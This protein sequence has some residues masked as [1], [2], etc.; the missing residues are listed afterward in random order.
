[1]LGSYNV[2]LKFP[3][4]LQMTKFEDYL[5]QKIRYLASKIFEFR[6]TIML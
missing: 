2:S 3:F 1:M 6:N 5:E 4:F